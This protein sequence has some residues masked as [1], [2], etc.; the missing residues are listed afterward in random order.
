MKPVNIHQYKGSF[1]KV[2]DKTPLSQI[3]TMTIEKGG[4]S[5]PEEIHDGDQIVYVVEGEAEVEINKKKEIM[6]K[7]DIVTIPKGSQHHIYNSGESQLFFLTIYTPP[8]Y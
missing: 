1:F 6:K 3:G 8:Q 4:D 2:L 5:G 7:G